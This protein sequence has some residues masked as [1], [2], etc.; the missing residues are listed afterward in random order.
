MY[1]HTN[2]YYYVI[3]RN[4]VLMHATM[5]INLRNIILSEKR[6]TQNQKLFD[7]MYMDYP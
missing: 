2:E 4:E 5:L 7:S 3:K 1:I 6:Q